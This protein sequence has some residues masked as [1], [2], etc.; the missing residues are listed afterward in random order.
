MQDFLRVTQPRDAAESLL[1][2]LV[3]LDCE[4]C[5][6]RSVFF[7]KKVL[8]V[9]RLLNGLGGFAPLDKRWPAS[10]VPQDFAERKFP[11]CFSLYFKKVQVTG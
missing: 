9:V 2:F 8:F 6:C 7:K 4:A 3:S 10:P 1:F 5:G 11:I